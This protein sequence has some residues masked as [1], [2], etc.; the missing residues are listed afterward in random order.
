MD[1]IGWEYTPVSEVKTTEELVEDTVTTEDTPEDTDSAGDSTTSTKTV[2]LTRKE[3]SL[4]KKELR[5]KEFATLSLTEKCNADV[6]Y[7]K[8]LK[9][10][11]QIKDNLDKYNT[12]FIDF[13]KKK[14]NKIATLEKN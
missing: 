9:Q 4:A 1:N 7:D 6:E 12:R 2:K 10:I 11:K 3:L 8:I 5:I 13:K 14:A